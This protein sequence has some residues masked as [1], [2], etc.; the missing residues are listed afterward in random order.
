MAMWETFPISLGCL[1]KPVEDLL[2][3]FKVAELWMG[4]STQ[5]LKHCMNTI[6]KGAVWNFCVVLDA[7]HAVEYDKGPLCNR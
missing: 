1:H 4:C 2:D 7:D 5:P 6:F 3:I